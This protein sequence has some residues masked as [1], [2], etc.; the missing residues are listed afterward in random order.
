MAKRKKKHEGPTKAKKGASPQQEQQPHPEEMLLGFIGMEEKLAGFITRYRESRNEEPQK[1][2]LDYYQ[3]V[4]DQISRM[5]LMAY[6]PV[7]MAQRQQ[8]AAQPSTQATETP[9]EKDPPSIQ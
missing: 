1:P 7:I 4:Q 2:V 5:A 3:H 6:A 9:A 8:A